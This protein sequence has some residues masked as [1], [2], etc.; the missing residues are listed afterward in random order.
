[1]LEADTRW[2]ASPPT[3]L[4]SLKLLWFRQMFY[5]YNRW[6]KKT[7]DAWKWI[8]GIVKAGFTTQMDAAIN[9]QEHV[10]K[11]MDIIR[12][13]DLVEEIA[14]KFY[15]LFF[16]QSPEMQRWF[17]KV[18][19]CPFA[20]FLARHFACSCRSGQ[21]APRSSYAFI[22]QLPVIVAPLGT[23]APEE[24]CRGDGQDLGAHAAKPD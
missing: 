20:F 8:W 1:M 11:C 23:S 5:T 17:V 12:E 19:R 6:D 16:R 4:S 21:T 15:E 24:A 14:Y 18:L 7:E 13:K 2:V 3:P 22:I 9:M 10:S